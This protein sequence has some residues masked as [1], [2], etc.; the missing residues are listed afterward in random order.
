MG[1]KADFLSPKAISNR[2]K[3]KGLQKLRWYCQ[4]CQKQC[5]DENGFKCHTMSESHQRQMMLVGENPGKYIHAFSSEFFADFMRLLRHSFG[6][7]RVHSNVVYQE[8]IKDK[9][10]FHMNSTRWTTLSGFVR[11]LGR[12]GI[13]KV[14]ET[15][16]GLFLQYIEKD[17]EGRAR[18]EKR[19][20]MAKDDAEREAEL[21]ARQVE[22]GAAE[23]GSPEEVVYTELKRDEESEGKIAF[24]LGGGAVAASKEEEEVPG[25]P[26][27]PKPISVFAS[28]AKKT[29]DQK[30]SL[31]PRKRS[32][33]DEIIEME[34]KKRAKVKKHDNWLFENIVVKVVYKKLGDRYHK[35]KG[36]VRNVEDRFL[37]VVKM[38]DS[39]DVLKVDQAH[40]E[41]VIPAV[42]K[43]VLILNGAYRGLRAVLKKLDID[44]YCVDVEIDEGPLKG[45]A[46]EGI[47]YE[48]VSK[49]YE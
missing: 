35:R 22:K 43:P 17:P 42:G 21:I 6:T 46:V 38:L 48:D 37:G 29:T 47:A 27:P 7:T 26:P 11:F 31:D 25:P 2:I 3:S 32:A 39:G 4:M 45:R 9:H 8:Y 14:D 10:H 12:E 34:E 40:L 30:K 24:K 41:T 49:W 36:I 28:G 33:L 23:S 44:N 5:R 18:R 13:C 16:K 19:E 15:E 1:K 20:K